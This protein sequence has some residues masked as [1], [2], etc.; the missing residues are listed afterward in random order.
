VTGM[1][2]ERLAELIRRLAPDPRDDVSRALRVAT[3]RIDEA[4][5]SFRRS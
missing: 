1:L 5:V 2:R 4:S 3:V